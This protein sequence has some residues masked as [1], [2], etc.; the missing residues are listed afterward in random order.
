MATEETRQQVGDLTKTMEVMQ[1]QMLQQMDQMQ[2][3][4]TA[5]ETGK[6]RMP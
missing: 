2:K 1:K 4:M 6:F 5:Q 3:L